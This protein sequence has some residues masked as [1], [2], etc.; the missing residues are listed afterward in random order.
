[1]KQLQQQQPN[2]KTVRTLSDLYLNK[3]FKT[4]VFLSVENAGSCCNCFI[5]ILLFLSGHLF[6]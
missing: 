1:M 4:V 6:S 5:I 3:G 2:D